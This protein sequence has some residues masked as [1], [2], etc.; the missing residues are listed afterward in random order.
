MVDLSLLSERDLS[1]AKSSEPG[2]SAG[3]WIR[4]SAVPFEGRGTQSELCMAPECPRRPPAAAS[5]SMRATG[6]A[7]RQGK[8]QLEERHSE[9]CAE[10]KR[11]GFGES[12]STDC[13]YDP[14]DWID[15]SRS[16]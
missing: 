1:I 13:F 15:L 2:M 9:T 7:L 5:P 14:W 4:F 11:A 8:K 16:G 3:I 12:N 6:A 10:T